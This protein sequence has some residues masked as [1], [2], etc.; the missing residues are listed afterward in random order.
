M[1]QKSSQIRLPRT[2]TTTQQSTNTRYQQQQT[3]T[4]TTNS[5]TTTVKTSVT[6]SST[7]LKSGEVISYTKKTITTTTTSQK[8][9]T[10]SVLSSSSSSTK[11]VQKISIT[12]QK[13]YQ[14]K[15]LPTKNVPTKNIQV[16]NLQTKNPNYRSQTYQ[17]IA[18]EYKSEKTTNKNVISLPKEKLKP[19]PKSP[20]PS[21]LK[22]R[23]L[24]RGDS[25][26]NIQITHIIYTKLPTEFHIF[27]VLSNDSLKTA[28]MNLEENREKIKNNPASVKVSYSSSC[29][30]V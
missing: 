10:Q 6:S 21:G 23:T 13:N 4:K 7:P 26:D 9:V 30:D 20:D 18:D 29:N 28:P 5:G 22:R 8:P 15:N 14:Q 24:N 27:E 3:T 2:T 12:Q 1:Y 16:K 17:K 25:Y 11:P 19:R